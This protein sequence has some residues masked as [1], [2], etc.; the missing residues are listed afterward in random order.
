MDTGRMWLAL[1]LVNAVRLTTSTTAESHQMQRLLF[2]ISVSMTMMKI[3]Q[4]RMISVSISIHRRTQ[5]RMSFERTLFSESSKN[6][7]SSI[8]P[9]LEF[10]A[11]LG[12][13]DTG[14]TRIA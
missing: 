7:L 14:T 1:S 5:V 8:Q 13:E 12:V 3:S 11:T 10:I 4:Y 9:V 6:K 2:L